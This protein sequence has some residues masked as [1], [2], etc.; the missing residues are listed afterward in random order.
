MALMKV[1][2]GRHAGQR[3]SEWSRKRNITAQ[4]VEAVVTSPEQIV[5]GHAGLQ[6]AQSRME[7]GLLRVPFFEVEG[8]RK[9]VTVYW[10]SRITR[11][12]RRN[13]N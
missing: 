3:L 10:T 13:A 2:W 5:A 12:W 4:Q 9:I 8:D 1:I 7:H 6:V 11:Y